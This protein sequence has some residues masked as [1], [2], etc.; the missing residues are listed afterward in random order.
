MKCTLLAAAL[1][2]AFAGT[3]YAHGGNEHVRG[4]VKEITPTMITIQTTATKTATVKLDEKT[5][6]MQ[7]SKHVTMHDL[8][9]GER[10]VVDVSDE[11]HV[12]ESVT[13]GAPA[14]AHK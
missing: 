12:A 11:T 9:V 5:M 4:T 3:G 10:V 14:A 7:S 1:I 13:F 2:L 8:K 6:F